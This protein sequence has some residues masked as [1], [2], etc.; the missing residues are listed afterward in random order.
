MH[1]HTPTKSS[2]FCMYIGNKT[3]TVLV[4]WTHALTC[5]VYVLVH[6]P[7]MMV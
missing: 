3:I 6:S 4:M 7:N 5:R 1:S 2:V